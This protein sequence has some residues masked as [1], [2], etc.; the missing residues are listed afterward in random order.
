MNGK[1]LIK[2]IKA[3]NARE[4]LEDGDKKLSHFQLKFCN[5]AKPCQNLK[6][7]RVLPARHEIF[8]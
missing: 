7:Q 6:R 8:E 4:D 1:A 2:R 5:Q 3:Y